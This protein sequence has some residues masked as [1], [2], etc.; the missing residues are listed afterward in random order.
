VLRALEDQ[1]LRDPRSSLTAVTTADVALYILNNKRAFVTDMERRYGVVIAVQ[2]SDR[3]QGANFAIERSAV[4]A[5][6]PQRAAE[7]AVVNME[8][9]FERQEGEEDVR[10]DTEEAT[11]RGAGDGGRR[12]RR[13]RRRGRRDE[14]GDDRPAYRGEHRGGERTEH[15][16]NG[17]V[18]DV[19][20]EVAAYADQPEPHEDLAQEAA[21]TPAG[22]GEQP[23]LTRGEE[24]REERPGRRRRRGRRGG[25]RGRD[26]DDAPR[27]HRGD[28]HGDDVAA[29]ASE[30]GNG[31]IEPDAGSPPQHHEFQEE[32][33]AAVA[34]ET[35][36]HPPRGERAEP[37]YPA[38]RERTPERPWQA[39]ADP[40]SGEAMATHRAEPAPAPESAPP[41]EPEP[42]HA[43]RIAE[44]VHEDPSRPVRKG[45]WQRRFSGE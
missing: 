28:E 13:R 29:H 43:E 36:Q 30:A 38:E 37:R 42:V 16:H 26:R 23:S 31:A 39:P 3:M 4:Q 7:R 15:A 40:Y 21:D 10:E 6:A 2:A 34:E 33:P 20:P 35:A 45:W 11:E 25:R 14:R 22:F 18:E 8:S 12:P 24:G 17:E 9:G 27:E 32:R 1:L 19:G 5:P 41:R 44:P